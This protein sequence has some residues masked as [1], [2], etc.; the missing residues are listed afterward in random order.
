MIVDRLDAKMLGTTKISPIHFGL[1]WKLF[2]ALVSIDISDHNAPVRYIGI[3]LQAEN[4]EDR[5]L[6]D[7]IVKNGL[8]VENVRENELDLRLCK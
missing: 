4:D 1:G 5:K 3:R 8:E 7:I 6:L 2:R